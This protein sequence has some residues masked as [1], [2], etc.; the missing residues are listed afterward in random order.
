MTLNDHQPGN[1][2]PVLFI[3][4]DGTGPSYRLLNLVIETTDLSAIFS[5]CE[6]KVVDA[7]VK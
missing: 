3:K 2:A 6:Y 1:N 4:E 5:L 7:N